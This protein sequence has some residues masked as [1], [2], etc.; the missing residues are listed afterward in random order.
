MTVWRDIVR[1]ETGPQLEHDYVVGQVLGKGAFGVVR[2]VQ[3]KKMGR[4]YACKSIS[5]AK[6]I[7]KEDVDD[8]R[9][10]V[11]I[12]NL[13]SPHR[14]VAGLSQ[15]YE[16]RMAVHIVMELCAGG[17]LFERIVAKGT[18]SE[19]EAARHF[20]TM[21]EMVAHLHALGVMHRDI[22][23]ENFLLTDPTDAADLKACDFGLSDFFKPGQHFTS[24][25]GSAY[26][27][28]PEVLRRNY[29]PQCDIWSLG[30]VLYILLSG[31]PPFWGNDEKEIFTSI[32]RGNLDF[33]TA[34]WPAISDLAKDLVRSIL[35]FDSTQRATAAQILQHPW[36]AAQG[37]APDRPLD[38]VVITRLRNF[39][40]MTRLRKAAILAAASSLS[41]E[42]IHGL[43][44]LF[45]SFDK[46]GDGH[47]T[48][49]ELR[50]GL[51]HQGVLADGEVEQILRDTDV[52]G[53]G[54]IDY[55]EFVA[56]TVNLNLL[57][58]EEVCIKAFQ[59]LDKDGSGTLTAD[60][61]AEAMGMAGKMTEEEVKE[62]ITR[63]DVDGNG[64]I[65]Y[66]EFIKMLHESDPH[67]KR[68]SESLK[69]GVVG[70]HV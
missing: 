70:L 59:K 31:M 58:R 43:R 14:T 26:Y 13:V 18:F 36:L 56:S 54:V 17:E 64:V 34:P 15:V 50:E 52:D 45:K 28:A 22:K 49:D 8:V 42:E 6:L 16:D 37:A 12:L 27:V 69:R 39:A 53:N 20:R 2:L 3:D 67:L 68:A 46:N 7:S 10:E 55:E 21:V 19:A 57:E 23:P 35:T 9:R 32:L 60:E 29:G 4:M 66:A 38:N 30:V 1:P 47:I 40:G 11:E 25:I 63:Y 24:L 51:A 5:K 33:S 61:V 44:E 62:M 41:H 65:D 48:L